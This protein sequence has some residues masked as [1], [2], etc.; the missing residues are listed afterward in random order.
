MR[1]WLLGTHIAR[2][3]GLTF[4]LVSLTPTAQVQATLD[5]FGPHQV[6]SNE[7]HFVATAWEEL[8]HFVRDHAQPTPDAHRLRAYLENKTAGYDRQGFLRP[9]FIRDLLFF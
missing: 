5:G 6:E 7:R 2:R 9:A 4:Y 8:Y 1:L 3:L